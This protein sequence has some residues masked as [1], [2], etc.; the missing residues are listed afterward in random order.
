MKANKTIDKYIAIFVKWFRQQ[1]SVDYFDI[2]IYIYSPMSKITF[3]WM[4][5][6]IT[7]INKLEI[8]QRDVKIAFLNGDLDNEVYMEQLEGFVFNGYEKKIICLSNHYMV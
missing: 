5:V 3:I 2:Y 1:E 7:T 6:V 8:Y 4:L